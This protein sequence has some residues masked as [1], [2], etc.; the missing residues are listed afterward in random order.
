MKTTLSLALSSCV[1]VGSTFGLAAE[2]RALSVTRPL[3]MGVEGAATR[4]AADECTPA[5]ALTNVQQTQA[6]ELS[7]VPDVRV[8]IQRYRSAHEDP[9]V[10]L[11]DGSQVTGRVSRVSRDSFVIGRQVIPFRA[12]VAFLDSTLGHEIAFVQQSPPIAAGGQ[13]VSRKVW[14]VVVVAVAGFFV[15]THLILSQT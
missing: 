11:I 15:V 9:R 4:L 6:E 1:V 10:E 12:V 14:L 13:R 5:L 7:I 2:E 8:E 3:A